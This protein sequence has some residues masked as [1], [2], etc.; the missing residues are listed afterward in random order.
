MAMHV[1]QRDDL[2]AIAPAVEARKVT[3]DDPL[4]ELGDLQAPQGTS[5][6]GGYTSGVMNLTATS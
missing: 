3:M 1:M 2:E 6:L 4:N 5:H